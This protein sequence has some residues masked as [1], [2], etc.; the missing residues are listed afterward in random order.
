[1]K[2]L[3]I[4]YVY[5]KPYDNVR[6]ILPLKWDFRIE[7][8][9]DPVFIEYDGEFHYFPIRQH[10]KSQEQAQK[11]LES[12]QRRDKIKDN[13]CNDNNLLLLRIP[14]WDKEN[15]SELVTEFLNTHLYK[16]L[17]PTTTKKHFWGSAQ[18]LS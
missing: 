16:P 9:G 18:G 15:I 14:Y 12:Q 11:N 5:D 1:M 3:D 6:D 17:V 8:T 4:D 10:V 7:T 2:K 13:Y